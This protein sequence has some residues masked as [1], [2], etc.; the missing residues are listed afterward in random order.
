MG[1]GLGRDDGVLVEGVAFEIQAQLRLCSPDVISGGRKKGKRVG[2]SD[3]GATLFRV[4]MVYC[5]GFPHAR[6][7]LSIKKTVSPPTV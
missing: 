1:P 7:E 4:A 3:A 2:S 6:Q 5:V